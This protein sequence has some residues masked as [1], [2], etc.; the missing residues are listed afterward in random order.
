MEKCYNIKKSNNTFIAKYH[1]NT[2]FEENVKSLRQKGISLIST[3]QFGNF[4]LYL[5]VRKIAYNCCFLEIKE[6]CL[7]VFSNICSYQYFDG[8]FLLRMKKYCLFIH[9]STFSL[10]LSHENVLKERKKTLPKVEY[11]GNPSKAY[12]DVKASKKDHYVCKIDG[13]TY[14]VDKVSFPP[15]SIDHK[16]TITTESK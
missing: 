16:L 15:A 11:S 2:M 13:K 1:G 8:L 9:P 4:S 12:I 7:Q 6:R 10:F 3:N 14:F 5:P